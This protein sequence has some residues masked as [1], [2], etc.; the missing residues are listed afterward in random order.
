VNAWDELAGLINAMKSN[1][2]L[3]L[4]RLRRELPKWVGVTTKNRLTATRLAA[5]QPGGF[6]QNTTYITRTA[7]Y[8]CYEPGQP[9]PLLL[10]HDAKGMPEAVKARIEAL[11]GFWPALCSVMPGLVGAARIER[12]S[13]S[14]GITRTDTGFMLPGGG[15][16]VY[17]LIAD[18]ADAHR[19]LYDLHKRMWLAGFGY[20]G[21]GKSGQLL[22][23]SIV[24]RMVHG[25]ERLVFEGAPVLGEGLH[26]D[27]TARM[28]VAH[29]G[30]VL[31][32]REAC[33]SLSVAERAKLNC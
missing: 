20:Y 6:N 25:P 14:T 31:D 7:E 21:L 27:K 33:P 8:F 4:G 26:Q 17:L 24:D 23:R 18:G 11:G 28:A 30:A 9:A 29:D 32:T 15:L 13:T 10:D 5:A 2:A 16:H 12:C 22:D 19:F 3:T 1:E